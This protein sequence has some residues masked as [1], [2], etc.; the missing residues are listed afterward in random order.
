MTPGQGFTIFPS[1]NFLLETTEKLRDA[2]PR[3]PPIPRELSKAVLAPYVVQP[4]DSLLV[5]PESLET[6]LKFAADQTVLPDGAIDLGPY[7]RPIV[8]GK[9]IEQ[10]EEGVRRAA[11]E[12]EKRDV[13]L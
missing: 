7:G 13:P 3:R 11:R 2:A 4:G 10:I 1:G 9:T 6:P 5:E 8:A 12:V